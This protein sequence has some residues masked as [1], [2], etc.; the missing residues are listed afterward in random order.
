VGETSAVALRALAAGRVLIVYDEGW[1][2]ELP[3]DARIGL[4]PLD[5]D[6]LRAAMR[7]LATDP[8]LRSELGRRGQRYARE[9]HAPERAAASY[10]AF[11]EQ[12]LAFG[13]APR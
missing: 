13:G 12:L 11:V 3:S 10:L 1:Y 8:A 6:A 9:Q 2:A 5:D 7:T 4:P